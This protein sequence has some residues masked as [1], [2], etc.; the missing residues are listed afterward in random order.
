MLFRPLWEVLTSF[1]GN[2]SSNS[3][4]AFWNSIRSVNQTL[5]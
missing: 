2:I 5:D 3:E 4:S 1:G